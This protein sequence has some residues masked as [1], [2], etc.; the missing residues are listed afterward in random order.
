MLRLRAAE[1]RR[2]TVYGTFAAAAAALVSVLGTAG[3]GRAA[4]AKT[5]TVG[6]SW[7]NGLPCIFT[8]FEPGTGAFT[9]TGSSTWQGSWTGLTQFD[10]R[11]VVDP[12]TGDT[13]GTINEVFI[14]TSL[15]DRSTGSLRFTE[16]FT[17]AGATGAIVIDADIVGGGGDPTFRCS[18]GHATFTGFGPPG[19]AGGFGGWQGAWTHGCR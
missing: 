12:V 5:T 4:E 10:A 16:S 11:G 17:I 15:S 8:S 18:K 14:G 13:S 9:C 2:R 19:G 1:R 3:P 7:A 6:G